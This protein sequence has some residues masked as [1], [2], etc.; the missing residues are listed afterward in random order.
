MGF[1]TDFILEE[2]IELIVE[3]AEHTLTSVRSNKNEE[4]HKSKENTIEAQSSDVATTKI[5][6]T[7]PENLP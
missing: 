2:G 5:Y 7:E 6:M 1:L 4:E 3:L